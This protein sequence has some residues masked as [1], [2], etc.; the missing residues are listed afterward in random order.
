MPRPKKSV[1]AYLLHRPSG[2]AVVKFTAADGT[3]RMLYLGVFNSPESREEYERV[4]ASL[5]KGDAPP[6]VATPGGARVDL[7]V[8]EA[9]AAYVE[10]VQVY[11]PPRSARNHFDAL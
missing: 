6:A 8:T 10:H 4:L 11:Y 1:P 2:Q 9:L 5:R 3:R 7:T